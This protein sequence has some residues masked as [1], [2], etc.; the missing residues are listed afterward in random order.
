MFKLS[1]I[2]KNISGFED[3]IILDEEDFDVLGLVNYSDPLKPQCS[4]I[5]DQRFINEIKDNLRM[6]IC[7]PE[8]KDLAGG[9]GICIT[10]RPRELFFKVH[11]YLQNDEK[12]IRQRYK[13]IIGTSSRISEHAAIS[14]Y[15]VRIGAN[16]IIEEFASIKENTVIGDNSIIRAGCIVGGEGFEFKKINDGILPVKHLGGVVIGSNVEIQNNTCIDKAVYPWDDTII[17][18]HSKIDNLV[19][20]AHGVKIGKSVLIV[21]QSGILGRTRIGDNVKIGISAS[22]KNGLSIGKDSI[23]SMGAVVT[24]D[25]PEGTHV[26]G[27]FAIPHDRFMKFIK[28]IR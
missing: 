22:I 28:S 15:S 4:F 8:Y 14:P 5:D 9:R 17:G 18:D 2:I 25:I 13:S 3:S 10:E 19:Y 24:K 23:V 26:S 11:N 20:I 1:E 21:G 16:V 6:L 12:Y 7:L 27:N